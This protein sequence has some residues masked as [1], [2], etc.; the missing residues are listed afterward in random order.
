MIPADQERILDTMWRV[1]LRL[2][3]VTTLQSMHLA[4]AGVWQFRGGAGC[5]AS[6]D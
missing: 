2:Q 1:C 6:A 5:A 3:A 4:K